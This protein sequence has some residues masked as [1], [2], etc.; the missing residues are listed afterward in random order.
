ME[1]RHLRYLIA[2]AEEE[3]FG[4][5][6]DR[7]NV[8]RSAVSQI[9]ADLEVELEI[10]LFERQPQK[11][12]LTAAGR[13]MLPQ[14]KVMMIELDKTIS[15]GRRVS[16][17]KSGLLTIGYGSLSTHHP[18]FCAV[19][20][21]FHED[22]PDIVLSLVE[23]PSSRQFKAMQEG[24]IDAGF[25]HLGHSMKQA[26]R[27][28]EYSHDASAINLDSY[29]IDTASLGIIVPQDH[30]F[31]FYGSAR[32][33][34]LRNQPLVMVH[35]SR[36]SPAFSQF[37]RLCRDAGF[38]PQIIQEVSATGTQ[39]DLIS[40]G[41]GIGVSAVGGCHSYPSEL[42]SIRLTDVDYQISFELD[43]LKGHIE[44]ALRHFIEVVRAVN[45]GVPGMNSR[46]GAAD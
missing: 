31:A 22:Y 30:R 41:V 19:I 4:R 3:H 12:K 38:E 23:I 46:A 17:G 44:P 32:L 14:L 40:A 29:T 1:L 37:F 26:E 43:W 36:D 9:I 8:T 5:A 6:A 7:L 33:E 34:D 15:L 13:A 45:E 27:R 16:Q 35:N 42:S 10:A 21:R 28:K 20:K 39:Q 24:V 2:A 18:S 11:I 25:M